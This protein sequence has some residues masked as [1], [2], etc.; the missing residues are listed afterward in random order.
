MFPRRPARFL[1]FLAPLFAVLVLA[2]PP[3][4]ATLAQYD[5]VVSD[6]EANNARLLRDLEGETR[7]SCR[8]V[9]ALAFAQPGGEI[10]SVVRGSCEG[11]ILE[12]GRGQG[13]F[14]YDPFFLPVGET[15]SM[16]ELS[17]DEKA[18]ISHRGRATRSMRPILVRHVAGD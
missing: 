10:V 15:R 13:G 4:R 1:A 18:A 2:P 12:E 8:Y 17:P 5:S 3:A 11:M 6:D 14:G 16:A 9:C 7:R